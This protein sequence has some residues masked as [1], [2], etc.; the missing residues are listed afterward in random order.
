MKVS[1]IILNYNTVKDTL[2]C[3]LSLKAAK[4]P[5]GL[6]LETTVVD[7]ASSDDSVE[8]IKVKF[9]E[10]KLIESSSNLGFAGGNNLGIKSAQN[11]SPD[12]VMLLNSDTEVPGE[13][14]SDFKR[15]LE[16]CSFDV[17]SPLIYFAK[18]YEFHKDRYQKKDLGKVVWYAGG[19]IDWD[20][21]YGSNA[22]VDEVDTG[23]FK[24]CE[25][26]PFATGA[27][28]VVRPQVFNRIGLLNET[29]Y[30]YLEDLEF[31]LRAKEAGFKVGFVPFFHLWHKVSASSGGAGSA[32]S[33]YFITR[34]R[35]IFGMKYTSLRTRFAL[36]RE[37]F[38]KL[39][40]GSEP[41]KRGVSDFLLHRLG[42]GTW[43]K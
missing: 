24:T 34:N 5:K 40:F 38:K 41:Q 30:L 35:L 18:G 23:Q 13:F 12:F 16:S 29:Y 33:D 10:V 21:V 36:L 31:S 37:A 39:R 9:P 42:K 27:C 26:T 7:N 14:W 15:S 8:Q 28:L 32:L 17:F 43:L 11:E 3:L 1:L 6:S 22:H 20:N 4:L 19:K 25:E 2:E